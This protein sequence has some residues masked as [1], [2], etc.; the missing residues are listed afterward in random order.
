[1]TTLNNLSGTPEEMLDTCVAR[2]VDRGSDWNAFPE[3]HREGYR[4]A[5]HRYV[6]GGGSGK[7]DDPG[8]IPAGN[9]NISVMTIPPGQGT[10][11]HTHRLDEAFFLLK[12]YLTVFVEDQSGHRAE[13]VLGPWDCI[14]RPAGVMAGIFNHTVEPAYVQV[15]LPVGD[16]IP[17]EHRDHAKQGV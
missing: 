9:F 2:W 16:T 5:Q 6:G 10:T 12:G 1:M 7:H 4:R 11:S 8:V 3:A 15:I 14:A 17:V 13:T